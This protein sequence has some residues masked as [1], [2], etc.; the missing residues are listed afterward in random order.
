MDVKLFDAEFDSSSPDL[1]GCSVRVFN[2]IDG[3]Y[4]TGRILLRHCE[5]AARAN[6]RLQQWLHLVQ[7]KR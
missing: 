3:Q 1:V 5:G 6:G 7:F 2:L 4:H